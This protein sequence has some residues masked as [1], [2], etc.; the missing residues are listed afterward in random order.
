MFTEPWDS[1]IQLEKSDNWQ[2]HLHV[3]CK[4][5]NVCV[6]DFAINKEM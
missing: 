4:P 1:N 3:Y 6:Q 2:K 5:E